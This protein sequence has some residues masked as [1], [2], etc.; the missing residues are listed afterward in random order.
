MLESSSNPSPD[1]LQLLEHY[2]RSCC[3]V[4]CLKARHHSCVVGLQIAELEETN[5]DLEDSNTKLEASVGR[6]TAELQA[7]RD[8]SAQGAAASSAEHQQALERAHKHVKSLETN[9]AS[10]K[11]SGWHHGRALHHC[12][13]L[14]P[15]AVQSAMMQHVQTSSSCQECSC[16]FCNLME[17]NV[18][19]CCIDKRSQLVDL[20]CY[21]RCMTLGKTAAVR[22]FRYHDCSAAP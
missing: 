12:S 8:E 5:T 15:A 13:S 16:C 22:S 3:D 6:L 20:T 14:Q 9:V 7:A 4:R 2:I 21:D 1:I 11:V 10:L 18:E 19:P 17:S